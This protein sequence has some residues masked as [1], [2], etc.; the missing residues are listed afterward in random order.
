MSEERS[1]ARIVPQASLFEDRWVLQ[2]P[3]K[4]DELQGNHLRVLSALLILRRV[5]WSG[6][7]NAAQQS[8]SPWLPMTEMP[9]QGCHGL[10]S[11]AKG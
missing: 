1:T 8:H 4:L 5:P 7:H 11:S 9:D 3:A 2:V 6:S 10:Q